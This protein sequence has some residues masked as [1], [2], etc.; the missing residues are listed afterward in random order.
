M[1]NPTGRLYDSE[2]EL[3]TLRDKILADVSGRPILDPTFNFTAFIGKERQE[4]INELS[5]A[6]GIETSDFDFS[7][8]TAK[9]IDNKIK[10]GS[11]TIVKL[12]KH[13]FPYLVLFVGE[14]LLSRQGGHWY[15][16]QSTPTDASEPF[17][18]IKGKQINFFVDLFEDL[19]EQPRRYRTTAFIKLYDNAADVYF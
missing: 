5:V 7:L 14:V 19:T 17:L 9:R 8:T 16:S 3:Q 15:L 6:F 10:E 12:A 2:N 18:E 1:D 11:L 4:K 13:L